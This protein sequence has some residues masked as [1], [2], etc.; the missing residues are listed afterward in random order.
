[1]NQLFY[2]IAGRIV[3]QLRCE[4][5]TTTSEVFTVSEISKIGIWLY[6]SFSAEGSSFI[7]NNLKTEKFKLTFKG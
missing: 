4:K 3:H 7:F 2:N 1:M 5:R 6:F